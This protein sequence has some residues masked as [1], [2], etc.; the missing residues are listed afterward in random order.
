MGAY[1][2]LWL[3]GSHK[4]V[5]VWQTTSTRSQ[6]AP[7][8][9]TQIWEGVMSYIQ[10]N[11]CHYHNAHILFTLVFMLFITTNLFIKTHGLFTQ[12][13]NN[14]SCTHKNNRCAHTIFLK[15]QS[16]S[17][18]VGPRALASGWPFM[19]HSSRS[20]CVLE[21]SAKARDLRH[22]RDSPWHCTLAVVPQSACYSLPFWQQHTLSCSPRAKIFK[23]SSSPVFFWF[24]SISVFSFTPNTSSSKD[25]TS[26]S[27]F[28]SDFASQR[29]LKYWRL[30]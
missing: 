29:Q 16:W 30:Q 21:R 18:P 5:L 25:L 2:Q 17:N 15:G 28:I 10:I 27:V 14:V 4:Q 9:L 6:Q 26:T 12:T 1:L 8:T 11:V 7:F 13:Q 19:T 24:S 20:A 22:W 3:H 23:P